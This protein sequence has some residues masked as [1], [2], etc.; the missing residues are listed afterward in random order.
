[1]LSG[2]VARI[3][4]NDGRGIDD[5]LKEKIFERGYGSNTGFGLFFVREILS[6]TGMIIKETG[7]QGKGAEF[8]IVVPANA[9]RMGE[10]G[11]SAE[12]R[13]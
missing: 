2:M 7:E 10:P 13:V 1:M 8:M 11:I 12:C 3:T 6:I 9:Y 5:G 4:E